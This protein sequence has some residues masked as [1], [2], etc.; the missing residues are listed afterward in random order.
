M[1]VR[2]VRQLTSALIISSRRGEWPSSLYSLRQVT[3][4]K[5][6]QVRSNSGW[7]TSEAGTHNSPRH[8]SEWTLN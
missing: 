5:L 2:L 8:P 1:V 7:V 6:G 4:L 3:E